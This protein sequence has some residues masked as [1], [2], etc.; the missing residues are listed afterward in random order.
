VQLDTLMGQIGCAGGQ[1]PVGAGFRDL[2]AASNASQAPGGLYEWDLTFQ[3]SWSFG[4]AV[5]STLAYNF[6]IVAVCV[7]Y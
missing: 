1:L 7:T 4:Y 2:T 6:E 3:S 5:S